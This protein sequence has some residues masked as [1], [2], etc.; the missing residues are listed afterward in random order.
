MDFVNAKMSDLV[1]Y[2]NEH[3]EKPTNK[4]SDRA[5]AVKRC[6]A[7]QPGKVRAVK[8]IQRT[9]KDILEMDGDDIVIPKKVLQLADRSHRAG[10]EKKT[11]SAVISVPSAKKAEPRKQ[12]ESVRERMSEGQRASWKVAEIREARMERSA[13]DVDGEQYRSTFAAIREL[14]LDISSSQG[15]R[16]RMRLKE[17]GTLEEYG[18]TWKIIPLNN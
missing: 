6:M 12:S 8:P 11:P 9:T 4:F 15:I 17:E 5:T 1:A 7:L 14:E 2:Y 16:F 13:V 18:H 10:I 3:S